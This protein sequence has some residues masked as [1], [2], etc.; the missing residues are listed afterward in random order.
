MSVLLSKL[1]KNFSHAAPR[2][3][4]LARFQQVELQRVLDAA[5]MISA[6]PAQLLDVGCGTGL[7][8][9]LAGA[10]RPQWKIMGVD[11]SEGMCGV[12][13]R[14]CHAIQSDVT[15]LP[16][17]ERSVD[18]CVS[19]LCLQWVENKP[20]AIAEMA[21]VLKPGGRLI[22]STLGGQT[23][24]ELRAAASAVDLP[25][26][27]LAMPSA[28]YYREAIVAAGLRILD[29][30]QHTTPELYPDVATMLNSM[31]QIGAG[32]NFVNTGRGLTG[33]RRWQAMLAQYE[34]HRREEGIPATWDRV[35][36]LAS[37]PQ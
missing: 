6:G 14:Y 19:S 1:Q 3:D 37:K 33:V 31:R 20:Q 17:A 12:A 5:R 32:N 25:L 11:I 34:T 24:R 28:A 16:I 27:L 22:L 10:D 13:Q 2:Y 9:Q 23:L 8:A 35:F 15:C 26:G 36:I 4:T 18:M 29:F 30:Q 21:R 7:F